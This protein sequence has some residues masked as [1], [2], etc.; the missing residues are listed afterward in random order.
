MSSCSIRRF[1][2]EG[3]YLVKKNVISI[4]STKVSFS[5][6]S[7]SSYISQKP[8][9]SLFSTNIKLWAYYVSEDKTDKKFYRWLNEVVGTEP[10]YY[11]ETAANNS[12]RQMELYLDNV[13][14]FHS[15][16][17]TETYKKRFKVKVHYNVSTTKPYRIRDISYD[18]A[19]SALASYVFQIKESFPVKAGD[20]YNAY[21][22]DNQRAIISDYLKDNG[23]Y[24]F[25]RDYIIY[26]IDSN[27]MDHSM[28]VTMKIEKAKNPITRKPENHK[29]Y[30]INDIDIYPDY[31]KT[32]ATRIPSDSSTLKVPM[33]KKSDN[34]LNFYF[35][36]KPRIRPNTFA[37][38]IQIEAGQPYC[39]K[40]VSQTYSAL[41]T[42]KLY[43]NSIIE[44]DTIPS[45]ANDSTHLLNCRIMLIRGKSKSYSLTAEGT[46]SD[47]DLGLKGSISFTNKNLFKGAEIFKL[48]VKGGWE[49]QKVANISGL[50]I[51]DKKFN[52]R[53]FSINGSIYFP[54]FLSPIPLKK[55]VRE[56]QPKTTLTLGYSTQV[57]YLYSRY[58]TMTSFGYD[59]KSDETIQHIFTPVSFN[60]VK[61]NP[62]PMFQE[63]LDLEENQR[64]KDQYTDHLILGTKYSFIFNNQNPKKNKNFIYLKANAESSGNLLSLFNKTPLMKKQDQYYEL[65]GIQY[66]Q[67]LRF[68]V[69][70]RQYI[71]LKDKH[72]LVLRELT[73][74]GLPYGNSYDIP[75]ERGF[76][77]GGPNGMRGWGYRELGPGAFSNNADT[78]NIEKIGDIQL[79][80]NAEFRFPIYS[81]LSGAI[82]VDAGNIWTYRENDLLPSGQFNIKEFYKQIALDAG[83]GLRVD[84]S[85]VIIRL[86]WAI[87]LRNP[88]PNNQG[89]YWRF[90]DLRFKDVTWNFG[91]G[92]PF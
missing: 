91:I 34:T 39:Y 86:D 22:L 11:S 28:K 13:G 41:S 12:A 7:L 56:Y 88:Y 78:L 9:K 70:F 60:S 35:F 52:T 15:K 19:D 14:Y 21:T 67:Y 6:S 54:R 55:F 84:V 65:F 49:A 64:I 53:E 63:L 72:W 8:Y 25:S 17:K 71:Q 2:P 87:P 83:L 82:F 23:Y 36:N 66:A 20:I 90:S 30:L 77:A 75:F 29:R 46:N 40:K 26:E 92:Y 74:L 24:F 3:E 4:D 79:E 42:L 48:T 51:D 62:I 76:Y 58:I 43:N 89:N 38:L 32:F 33:G 57:R 37:Q 85:F 27:Y 31:S 10:E 5:K 45:T 80:F 47:G 1:V 73:G 50:E 59:W 18:I 16:V 68:D 44:F 69:D 81:Y 61:V